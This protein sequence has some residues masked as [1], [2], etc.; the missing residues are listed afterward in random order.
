MHNLCDWIWINLSKIL[1]FLI[2]DISV[3]LELGSCQPVRMDRERSVSYKRFEQ[4]F[5]A[6]LD[7]MTLLFDK[8]ESILQEGIQKSINFE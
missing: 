2:W 3:A 7:L 4:K 8:L 5:E 1:F 6:M